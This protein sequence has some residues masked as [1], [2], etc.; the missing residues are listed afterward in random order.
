M[1]DLVTRLKAT[2][3]ALRELAGKTVP[4]P[5]LPILAEAAAEIATLRAE[6]AQARE[7]ALEEAAKVARDYGSK[8]KTRGWSTA[9]DSAAK[10][11]QHI[12]SNIRALKGPAQ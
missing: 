5:R 4:V 2:D 8:A 3:E 9:P 1:D 11:A 12:A 6:L 10:A 7:A